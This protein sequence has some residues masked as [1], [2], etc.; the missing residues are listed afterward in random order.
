MVDASESFGPSFNEK[1]NRMYGRFGKIDRQR[2]YIYRGDSGWK[3]FKSTYGFNEGWKLP[4]E[5]K[6]GIGMAAEAGADPG[7][8]TEGPQKKKNG[9]A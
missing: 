9:Y 2:T 5:V 3:Q 6:R 4:A 8:L 7:N 1:R